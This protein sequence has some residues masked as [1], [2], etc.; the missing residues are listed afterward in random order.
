MET[1]TPTVRTAS[2]QGFVKVMNH[3]LFGKLE[4]PIFNGD[5]LPPLN[6][7]LIKFIPKNA[8]AQKMNW[9]FEFYYENFEWFITNFLNDCIREDK[10]E[11]KRLY[12][13]HQFAKNLEALV[14]NT[15]YH[16]DLIRYEKIDNGQAL[17]ILYVNA[18]ENCVEYLTYHTLHFLEIVKF[19]KYKQKSITKE[20][21]DKI[22]DH[23]NT[24]ILK[25]KIE[26]LTN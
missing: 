11:G 4:N 7:D 13:N 3:L 19:I 25:Q 15:I 21:Y 6:P 26:F 17:S 10:N 16:T 2:Y 8:D 5:D 14:N 18:E 9:A 24:L 12:N 22:L 23:Y 1:K 20:E